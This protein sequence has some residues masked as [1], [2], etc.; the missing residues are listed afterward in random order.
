MLLHIL[1][2]LFVL[3]LESNSNRAMR[4]G[5]AALSGRDILSP[6]EIL[7]RLESVG[8]EDIARVIERF[9]QPDRLRVTS[10]GPDT[11]LSG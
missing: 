7:E 2:G 3:S 4:L 1:R 5:T 8:P 6:D 9:A 10:V 11:P